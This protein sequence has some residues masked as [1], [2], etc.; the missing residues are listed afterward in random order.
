MGHRKTTRP[1]H[2]RILLAGA[3]SSSGSGDAGVPA[4]KRLGGKD[5]AA[6]LHIRSPRDGQD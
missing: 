4:A 5:R 2:W 3:S 6:D 1:V